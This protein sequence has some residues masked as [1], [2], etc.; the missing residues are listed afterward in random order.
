MHK[1]RIDPR[2]REMNYCEEDEEGP[3]GIVGILVAN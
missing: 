1:G 2:K 3:Q